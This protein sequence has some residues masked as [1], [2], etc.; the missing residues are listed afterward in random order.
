MDKEKEK[1]EIMKTRGGSAERQTTNNEEENS[2][3]SEC[4]SPNASSSSEDSTTTVE[5]VDTP[6]KVQR[7]IEPKA[8]TQ[9]ECNKAKTMT[10]MQTKQAKPVTGLS[11]KKPVVAQK[12]QVIPEEG[13]EEAEA[14]INDSIRESTPIKENEKNQ[15]TKTNNQK[16]HTENEKNENKT[17]NNKAG[18]ISDSLNTFLEA[19]KEIVLVLNKD[20]NMLLVGKNAI[21]KQLE[22]MQK[23]VLNLELKVM[24]TQAR[25][26]AIVEHVERN[27]KPL[28]KAIKELNEK[29]EKIES[30]SA[31]QNVEEEINEES[32]LNESTENAKKTYA[33]IL[34]EAKKTVVIEIEGEEKEIEKTRNQLETNQITNVIPKQI[35]KTRKGMLITCKTES[36]ATQLREEINQ[37]NLEN[38]KTKEGEI[39]KQKLMIFNVPK[40]VNNEE[41]IERVAN[42]MKIENRQM[43]EVN[44]KI[45]KEKCNH[46]AITLPKELKNKM[47][48]Q[49][50]MNIGLNR[51]SIK[52]HVNV[53]RCY[54][55]LRYD[56]I[57]SK[58]TKL[59][60]NCHNCSK[61]HNN[62]QN[63]QDAPSCLNCKSYNVYHPTRKINENHKPTSSECNFYKLYL[64]INQI[65][66]NSNYKGPRVTAEAVKDNT[67]RL[68]GT[69]PHEKIEWS[70]DAFPSPSGGSQS[71]GSRPIGREN[72]SRVQSY[73]ARPGPRGPP[74]PQ[75][76]P[77]QQQRRWGPNRGQA[78]QTYYRR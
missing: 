15:T 60:Q 54:K 16:S 49:K 27:E 72:A 70:L 39:I 75:Q 13:A 23:E 52:P 26:D 29:I 55:C 9:T 18:K 8:K 2:S 51:C 62:T 64:K 21:L 65:K 78:H 69:A 61:E 35:K 77:Q 36:E 3:I 74:R 41:I 57:A 68:I 30:V 47:L 5:S 43:I 58:C 17:N 11:K 48:E 10:K 71:Y 50:E 6:P 31:P 45:E 28:Q 66:S 63:C 46:Y 24:E 42:E 76:R 1:G 19:K 22:I 20:K 33:Q 7:M 40:R 34:S 67:C 4:S 32:K 73:Q 56:H 25:A 12:N 37:Q 44:Y 59:N 14:A 53:T 38:I